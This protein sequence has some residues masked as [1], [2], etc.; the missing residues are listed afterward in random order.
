MVDANFIKKLPKAD[1]H[2]H[3]DG[4]LRSSTFFE[5]ADSQDIK[6]PEKLFVDRYDSLEE[7]LKGF[8]YTCAVMK[9][10]DEIERIAYELCCDSF[11]NNVFYLEIRFGPQLLVH[12]DLNEIQIL[13]ATTRGIR[14]AEDEWA[15]LLKHNLCKAAI[16]VCAI[17]SSDSL[18]SRSLDVAKVAVQ[19]RDEFGLPIVGFDL[20]GGEKGFPV[21]AHKPAFNFAKEAN[22]GITIHAAEAESSHAI[23]EAINDGHAVRIGHGT[24]IDF[25]DTELL[26]FLK[27]NK[28]ILEVC[29][30]SN[31]Q[32]MPHLK[33]LKDH[34]ATH[35]NGFKI[36]FALSTDN[37][38]ISQTNL[39]QEI[40]L[41]VDATNATE[42]DCVDLS[43]RA[44]EASFFPGTVVEK[45]KYLSE[46]SDMLQACR[47]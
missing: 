44:F 3:L 5:L 24:N 6:V 47:S 42:K 21:S 19:A 40:G 20:A 15:A 27:D 23:W 34:P 26:D 13:E 38:L 46:I 41:Y 43:E 8:E 28:I 2:V 32:T 16:I 37:L 12:K 11:S 22:L 1:L 31:L 25:S 14:R 10:E 30:T 4:S 33:S 7:Y 35:F 39:C 9:G 36:P 17:R 18:S 29:L 45:N